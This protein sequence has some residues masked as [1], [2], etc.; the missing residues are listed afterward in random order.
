ML[1]KEYY[2]YLHSEE[3]CYNAICSFLFFDK[4][5]RIIPLNV[6]NTLD[7]PDGEDLQ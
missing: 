5:H 6:L 7:T 3:K 1:L 4:K 2:S